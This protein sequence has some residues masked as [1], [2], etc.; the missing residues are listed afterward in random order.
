MGGDGGGWSEEVGVIIFV[1]CGKQTAEPHTVVPGI[2]LPTLSTHQ[3][4][5]S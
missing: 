1:P 5:N 3:Q 2:L 4:C